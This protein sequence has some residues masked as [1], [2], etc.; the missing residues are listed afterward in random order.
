MTKPRIV[1]L[2]P[3]WNQLPDDYDVHQKAKGLGW[4]STYAEKLTEVPGF[5]PLDEF[6]ED[7][8]LKR[9]GPWVVSEE[10]QAYIPLVDGPNYYSDIRTCIVEYQPLPEAENPWVSVDTNLSDLTDEQLTD[11]GLTSDQFDEVRNRESVGV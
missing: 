9:Q 8:K 5:R 10:T 4:Y 6:S 3:N 1:V 11:I 2:V 7:G